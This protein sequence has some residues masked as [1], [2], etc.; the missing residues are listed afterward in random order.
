[1]RPFSHFKRWKRWEEEFDD[2][3]ECKETA[4]YFV[5]EAAKYGAGLMTRYFEI[6]PRQEKILKT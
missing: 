5:S 6:I 1:M 2:L 3:E 4:A